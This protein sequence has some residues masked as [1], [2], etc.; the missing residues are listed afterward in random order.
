[1]DSNT[2]RSI[3]GCMWTSASANFPRS[4]TG[5]APADGAFDGSDGRGV[6]GAA[7]T[8]GAVAATGESAASHHSD[9]DLK[10]RSRVF[11]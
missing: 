5:D 6:L 7:T 8:A 2:G 9:V 11:L 1:M 4:R 10:P 3:S